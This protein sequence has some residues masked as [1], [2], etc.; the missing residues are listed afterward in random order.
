MHGAN[1]LNSAIF[2][3]SVRHR[4]F[5]PASNAF[6]YRVSMMYLDLDELDQVFTLS[7]FF[8]R[9]TFRPVQ[10]RRSDYLEGNG[11]LKQAV[12]H[13]VQE[14]LGFR[15]LGAV[16]LLTNLRYFGF[17]INPISVYYCF[18]PD[19]NLVAMVAQVTNE[20]WSKS[21]AYVLPVNQG[22]THHRIDFSKLLHVSPFM[23]MDMCYQWYSNTPSEHLA[24]NIKNT[25]KGKKVFDATLALKRIP[26]T[27]KTLNKNFF[28]FP[29]MTL[30]V[31]AGIYW[32]ALKLLF[33]RV[34][35]QP[36]PKKPA[37]VSASPV[38]ER[39]H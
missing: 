28:E 19:E 26:I 1:L 37:P 38:L 16:R 5:S 20:P 27:S 8:S 4:R 14:Q 6:T 29:V 7:R 17:V 33:K 31:V 39:S 21:I 24:V 34:P 10:F 32:Q 3:G 11:D 9:K 13:T 30:K 15:P 22:A 36:Y 35:L 2:K 25:Q 18:D 12:L 23:P